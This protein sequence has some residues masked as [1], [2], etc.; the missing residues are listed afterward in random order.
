MHYD[1]I[2]FDLDGTLWNA[3][4]TSAAGWTDA[5]RSLGID[6]IVSL[7][8]I[9]SMTG[10]PTEKC[11]KILLPNE[12]KKYNNLLDVIREY[13]K[14][15]IGVLG[16]KLYDGCVETIK[17]LGKRFK[18]FIVSNCETWY[19]RAFLDHSGCRNDFTDY[20]CHGMSNSDKPVML[21]VLK[22]KYSLENP[23]YI[24]DLDSDKAAAEN[25]GYNFIF[26]AYGFGKLS[27]SC[28][29][30]NSLNELILYLTENNLI[31]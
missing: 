12:Y 7:R 9:E 4:E 27:E 17:E 14:A 23:I 19:L 21:K 22:K 13:E 28:K 29:S 26:A 18:L 31:N 30:I 5:L 10:K 2:V 6:R 11:V 3:A 1:S 16:G 20:D 15:A 24:G 25:A 8:E